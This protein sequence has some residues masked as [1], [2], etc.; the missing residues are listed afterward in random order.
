MQMETI[1]VLFAFPFKSSLI[2]ISWDLCARLYM[3]CPML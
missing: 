3:G 2:T 1:F